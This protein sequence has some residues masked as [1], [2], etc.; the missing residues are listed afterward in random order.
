MSSPFRV[1]QPQD[2]NIQRKRSSLKSPT[3]RPSIRPLGYVSS[4][5]VSPRKSP[6]KPFQIYQDPF[7]LRD[8]LDR[9]QSPVL[10]SSD[11][12]NLGHKRQKVSRKNAPLSDLNIKAFPGFI[13]DSNQVLGA[14]YQLLNTWQVNMNSCQEEEKIRIPSFVTPP[15]HRIVKYVDS[16][17]STQQLSPRKCVS[18]DDLERRCKRRL[19]FE[20]FHD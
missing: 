9:S 1:L 17:S 19:N 11:K 6:Q 14:K 18:V 12:E 13:A 5:S 3:K 7:Y 20:I 4:N 2:T 10:D 15:K 8:S 16:L